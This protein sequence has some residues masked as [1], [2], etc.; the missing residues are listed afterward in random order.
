MLAR[1]SFGE[2]LA[3]LAVL[4]CVAS[5]AVTARQTVVGEVF[6]ILALIGSAILL[7]AYFLTWPPTPTTTLC[8]P[9]TLAYTA[10]AC[11]GLHWVFAQERLKT[12]PRFEI[13]VGRVHIFDHR[14][15]SSVT[16]GS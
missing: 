6:G 7:D 15:L 16:F 14:Y 13:N 9:T 5:V 3:A 2:F 12:K 8:V 4:A 10:F 1:M 11:A